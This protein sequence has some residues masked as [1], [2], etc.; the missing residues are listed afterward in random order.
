MAEKAAALYPI[1]PVEAFDQTVCTLYHQGQGD[2]CELFSSFR[3]FSSPLT[4]VSFVL[5]FC[6]FFIWEQNHSQRHL[7]LFSFFFL[8][9]FCI[10]WMR[11]ASRLDYWSTQYEQENITPGGKSLGHLRFLVS[12][13]ETLLP[14]N[15]LEKTSAPF[16]YLLRSQT[17]AS[18]SSR[19]PRFH[20]C[21]VTLSRFLHWMSFKMSLWRTDNLQR[22]IVS[23]DKLTVFSAHSFR[24]RTHFAHRQTHSVSLKVI[25][26]P[27]TSIWHHPD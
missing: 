4:P 5:F 21:M 23:M 16:F 27:A 13:S 18:E 15:N 19:G 7:F 22:V 11:R 3:E 2:I 24:P 14:G 10:F 17:G 6:F 9:I 12:W 1:G 20:T 8:P 26:L 25:I